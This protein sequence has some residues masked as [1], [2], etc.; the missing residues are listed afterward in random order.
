MRS[1]A[2]ARARKRK[3]QSSMLEKTTFDKFVKS[4][5]DISI[6]WETIE[7][8]FNETYMIKTKG[9]LDKE[10]QT[11]STVKKKLE[12]AEYAYKMKSDIFNNR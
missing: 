3:C 8:E 10:T 5:S 1:R 12:K 4:S 9:Q 11:L 6:P 2:R 7:N